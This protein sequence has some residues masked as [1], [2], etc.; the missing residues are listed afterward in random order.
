M[1]ASVFTPI[2]VTGHNS[3]D[4]NAAYDAIANDLARQGWSVVTNFFAPALL[5]SLLARLD[6]LEAQDALTL[7]GIGRGGDNTADTSIRRDK[8]RWLE[9]HD[10]AE[11]AYLQEMESLRQA[12][13]LRLMLGVFLFESHFSR[14]HS[15]AFYKRHLDSFRGKRNRIISTVTYLNNNWNVAD[16]G[17]LALYDTMN[18]AEPFVTIAPEEGTF[19]LF[20]SEETPHEVLPTTRP[21][22]SIAG[23]F[24]CNDK[25][26]APALQAPTTTGATHL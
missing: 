10:A 14:Y 4:R 22:A 26:E 2:A 3:G 19:V 16:G 23:W 20:L 9:R 7:S 6:T 18:C 12:L 5:E 1:P 8:T 11:T 17:L 24:R 21:R 15:G 25:I 13:N